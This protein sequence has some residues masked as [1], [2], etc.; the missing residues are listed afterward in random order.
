MRLYGERQRLELSPGPGGRGAV[1]E[2][3]LPYR[4]IART[5]KEGAEIRAAVAAFEHASV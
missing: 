5:R 2:V 3:R 1:V 4:Q